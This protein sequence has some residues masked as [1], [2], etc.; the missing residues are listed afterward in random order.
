MQQSKQQKKLLLATEE[1]SIRIGSTNLD[2]KTGRE[3]ISNIHDV[4][5]SKE[6]NQSC[7][8]VS[9]KYLVGHIAPRKVIS[10]SLPLCYR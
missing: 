1:L 6:V 4:Y 10:C 7:L 9:Q 5:M 3:V 2:P 8:S